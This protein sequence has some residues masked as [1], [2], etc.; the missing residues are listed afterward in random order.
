MSKFKELGV[1]EKSHNLTLH[2]YKLTMRFP[3]EEKY[4]LTSQIRKA[5][6]SIPANI[7][8]G[9][10]RSN[11]KEFI[12]FLRI[13]KG[14]ATELEYWLL[15]SHELQYLDINEYTDL[16]KQ[17]HKILAMLNNLITSLSNFPKK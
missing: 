2:I 16:L 14:S 12:N 7:A 1:W 17:N 6:S 3:S 4:G 10:G 8:E 5:A 9:Q 15:L 13:A 11:N